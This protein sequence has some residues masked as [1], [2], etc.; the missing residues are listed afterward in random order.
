[1]VDAFL[2]DF[3]FGWGFVQVV[4]VVVVFDVVDDAVQDVEWQGAFGFALHLLQS[5]VVDL[6]VLVGFVADFAGKADDAVQDVER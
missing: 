3:D 4:E 5:L 6:Q 2:P 1:M